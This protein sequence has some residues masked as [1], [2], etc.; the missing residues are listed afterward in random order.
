METEDSPAERQA[1]PRTAPA[2]EDL[3]I[4][5]S[6]GGAR[7]AY[8]VGVLRGMARHLPDMRFPIVAGVSAGAI[9]A[10]FL[11]SHPGTSAEA[12]FALSRL[13]GGLHVEEI[14]RVD[15]PSLS[16]DVLRWV[17]WAA[18][19]ATGDGLIGPE[20]RGL[21]DT[22]PLRQTIRHASAT[23]DGEIIGIERNLE[24]GALRAIAVTALNYMT[25]QSVT[26]VQGHPIDPY[27]EPLR[28]SQLTRLTVDHIMASCSLPVLF[29]AVRLASSWYGDGGVRLSAPLSPALRLGATRILAISPNYE[30]SHEEAD[31]PQIPGYPPIAQVLSQLLDSIFLDVLDEDV[32]RLETM[33]KL[34]A[35]IPPGNRDPYRPMDILVLRPSVDL[36]KL[37]LAYEP[38]LPDTFRVI[39]SSLGSQE[40]NTSDFLSMLMFQPDY[41]ERLMEIGESDAEARI[42]ELRAFM[43]HSTA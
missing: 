14:F 26:W 37:A 3:A 27:T 41:L 25:G 13:W 20:M 43:D 8:Q 1:G 12:A 23:V 31:R 39:A 9:N 21:L 15:S 2:G 7:A 30:P 19:L 22:E 6:G 5:L 16:R 32:K 17:R 34:I 11:A 18:R 35:K 42:D 10:A 38:R 28:R 40:S 4:V 33:N 24:R 29:P 36:G